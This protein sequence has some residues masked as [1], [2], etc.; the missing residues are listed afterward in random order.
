MKKIE[1]VITP[2][3]LGV[4]KDTLKDL[5]CHEIVLSEVRIS[6][7]CSSTTVGHYRGNSC[8]LE[9]P[10]LKL[11]AIVPDATAMIAAKAILEISHTHVNAN[12]E[13][14]L[15]SLEQVVSIGVSTVECDESSVLSSRLG[16]ELH[17]SSPA[18][19]LHA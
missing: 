11:E 19:R 17:G 18:E 5:E 14:S 4:V 13:V 7:Q 16:V 9:L 10:K 1:V 8:E 2:E 12:A 6:R 15:C 3:I